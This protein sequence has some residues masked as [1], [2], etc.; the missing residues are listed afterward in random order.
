[1]SNT[2]LKKNLKKFNFKSNKK[3][4]LIVFFGLLGDFDSFEYAI[5]LSKFI[6]SKKNNNLD[7]FFIAIGNQEGKEK[8]CKYTGFP[9]KNIK[10]VNNNKLHNLVGA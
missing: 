1:M 9:K 10:V 3:Y 7:I 2:N 4:R 5:N 6:T 8:F